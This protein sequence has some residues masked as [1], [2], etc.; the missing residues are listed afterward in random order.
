MEIIICLDNYLI[1]KKKALNSRRHDICNGSENYELGFFF[2]NSKVEIKNNKLLGWHVIFRLIQCVISI[3]LRFFFWQ[4]LNE[5][6]NWI[7]RYWLT[8]LLDKREKK[9]STL[10]KK[11]VYSSRYVHYYDHWSLRFFFFLRWLP[12]LTS[13]LWFVPNKNFNWWIGL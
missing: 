13:V 3:T 9:H 5:L 6:F 2:P 11:A 10:Q 1:E 8:L 7:L 4:W 12:Q